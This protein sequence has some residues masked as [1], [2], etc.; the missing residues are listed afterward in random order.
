MP[1]HLH[2][3]MGDFWPKS[4][5]VLAGPARSCQDDFMTTGVNHE[6][7]RLAKLARRRRQ[8]LGL[9]LNDGN[10]KAAGVSKGTWQRV[11]KGMSIRE[12]NYVKID[13][14]LQWAPGSCLSVL[15]GKEPIRIESV[16]GTSNAVIAEMDKG[17]INEQ[18]R[19]AIQLSLLATAKGATAEEIRAMSERVVKDLI[20]RGYL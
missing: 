3:P 9:A 16:E 14:L 8:E 6:R 10:A 17:E 20:E 2:I 13:G 1:C 4:P 5:L 15:E 11:E 18:A 7:E 12:T 19:D